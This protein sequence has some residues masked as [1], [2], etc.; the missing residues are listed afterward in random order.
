MMFFSLVGL[1]AALGSIPTHDELQVA[2]YGK[3]GPHEDCVSL[4]AQAIIGHAKKCYTKH[5]AREDYMGCTSNFCFN[6]CGENEGCSELC[7]EKTEQAFAVFDKAAKATKTTLLQLEEG[8]VE[9]RRG[10]LLRHQPAA[11]DIDHHK[12]RVLCQRFMFKSLGEAFKDIDH[13]NDCMTK[14]DEVYPAA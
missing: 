14:C 2:C 5:P 8:K 11:K 3:D 1:S 10:N 9:I 13:P 4:L 7:D 12:C 6:E